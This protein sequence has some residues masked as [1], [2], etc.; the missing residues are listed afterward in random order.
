V[1]FIKYV[2]VLVVISVCLFHQQL[3]NFKK[4]EHETLSG[5]V[6]VFILGASFDLNPL[7]SPVD[8]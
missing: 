8:L 4:K 1:S 2:P 6:S 5:E 7:G 3:H